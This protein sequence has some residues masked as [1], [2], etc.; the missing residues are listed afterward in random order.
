MC[1]YMCNNILN[2]NFNESNYFVGYNK[3]MGHVY[4]GLNVLGYASA[5]NT[6]AEWAGHTVSALACGIWISRAVGVARIALALYDQIIGL[7]DEWD[8]DAADFAERRNSNIGQIARGL[9]EIAGFAPVLLIIDLAFTLYTNRSCCQRGSHQ[10][11]Q[12]PMSA[13]SRLAG[14]N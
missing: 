6:V 11:E 2:S 5:V 9:A 1:L 10:D 13:S 8:G 3:D 14:L 7:P 4:A 12:M